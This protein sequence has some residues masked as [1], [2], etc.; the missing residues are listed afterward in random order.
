MQF[1]SMRVI[2]GE[3]CIERCWIWEYVEE[4][5]EAGKYLVGVR[6]VLVVPVMLGAFVMVVVIV[7]LLASGRALR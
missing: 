3:I 2:V 5:N 4:E 7:M 1:G 6:V